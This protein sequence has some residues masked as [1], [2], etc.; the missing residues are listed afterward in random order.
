M[1]RGRP[2]CGRIPL[3]LVVAKR[4]RQYS[5]VAG[6]SMRSALLKTALGMKKASFA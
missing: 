6:D 1:D 3:R 4:L 5:Y 2:R